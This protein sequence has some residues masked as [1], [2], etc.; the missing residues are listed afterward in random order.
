[1]HLTEKI[2]IIAV[3]T[4]LIQNA[5]AQT[6]AICIDANASSMEWFDASLNGSLALGS[7]LSTEADAGFSRYSEVK[8]DNKDSFQDSPEKELLHIS[9][10]WKY[11]GTSHTLKAGI[12]FN[13]GSIDGGQL[14]RLKYQVFANPYRYSQDSWNVKASADDRISTGNLS[15]LTVRGSA[16]FAGTDSK[17]GHRI[18][19]YSKTGFDAGFMY[20][21]GSWY[22]TEDGGWRAGAELKSE[23]YDYEY[24]FDPTGL[25]TAIT[26]TTQTE[27]TVSLVG[28][29]IYKPDSKKIT[30]LTLKASYSTEYDFFLTPSAR[31]AYNPNNWLQLSLFA[32]NN[33]RTVRPLAEN[34][35]ALSQQ[36]KGLYLASSR[37]IL[38]DKDLEQESSWDFGF[39][40]SITLPFVEINGGY[41]Y[42]YYKHHVITDFDT[43]AHSIH[44]TSSPGKS[45]VHRAVI[46]AESSPVEGLEINATYIYEDARETLTDNRIT[47]VPF[48]PKHNAGITAEYTPNGKWLFSASYSFLGGIRTPK[49]DFIQPLWESSTYSYDLLSI[50]I[51][52]TFWDRLT[53]YTGGSNLT[54]S[55]QKNTVISPLDPWGD[56]FDS[57]MIYMPLRG[58]RYFAGIRIQLKR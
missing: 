29:Y 26:E 37:L 46:S 42:R 24:R 44:F 18:S 28:G 2:L 22:S 34:N 20:E 19:N 58:A 6:D 32:E 43:D 15:A 45:Y 33:R 40:S 55:R 27:T 11:N 5:N 41:T 25:E 52:R 35:I 10:A 17:A 14:P 50:C 1:M 48:I 30:R 16:E 57:S 54:D 53:L 56:T 21:P 38:L 39:N 13:E 7:R 12:E 9:N 3:A 4:T 8:D 31:F 49:P 47:Q 36:D 51:E 23:R